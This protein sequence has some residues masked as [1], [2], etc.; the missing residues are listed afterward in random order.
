VGEDARRQQ[1]KLQGGQH[2]QGCLSFFLF[3]E[4]VLNKFA[5]KP[6]SL[7]RDGEKKK[8]ETE[9]MVDDMSPH[10]HFKGSHLVHEFKSRQTQKII[11][12]KKIIINSKHDFLSN[13]NNPPKDFTS[14]V[15]ERHLR[16]SRQ[17]QS[18]I[19]PERIEEEEENEK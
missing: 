9:I 17:R 7:V 4:K 11:V 15:R 16:L 6:E 8:K 3:L 18:L 2:L 13:S 14:T 19:K 5:E 12:Q 10:S 1:F